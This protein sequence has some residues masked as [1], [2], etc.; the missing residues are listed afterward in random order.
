MSKISE[1]NT[2]IAELNKDVE[3]LKEVFYAYKRLIA[4]VSQDMH[5]SLNVLLDNIQSL[6]EMAYLKGGNPASL[7]K[8]SVAILE[9]INKLIAL[10][11]KLCSLS[12]IEMKN[13]TQ[14]LQT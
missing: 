4:H 1:L 10:K 2:T 6:V 12:G 13:A 8:I 11:A 14:N 7:E 3:G 5:E 9:E